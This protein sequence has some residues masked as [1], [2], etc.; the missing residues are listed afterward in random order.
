[1]FDNQVFPDEEFQLTVY[2]SPTGRIKDGH[3]VWSEQSLYYNF[4]DSNYREKNVTVPYSDVQE[5]MVLIS[6]L[7][8]DSSRLVSKGNLVTLEKPFKEQTYN[9]ISGEAGLEYDNTATE[10]RQW[11]PFQDLYLVVDSTR[12]TE[13]TSEQFKHIMNFDKRTML[14]KPAFKT[15]KYWNLKSDMVP[16]NDTLA[17]VKIHMTFNTVGLWK[18]TW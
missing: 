14:Y 6:E 13:T 16:L 18:F 12:H 5:Q 3:V 11:L 15:S 4:T 7:K 1:V 2:L 10:I 8:S 17:E 9:L